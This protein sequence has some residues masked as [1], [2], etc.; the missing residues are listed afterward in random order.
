MDD[1]AGGRK[2]LEEKTLHEL[3]MCQQS[4]LDH[5]VSLCSDSNLKYYLYY[6]TLLG[7][8]RHKG[9]IP[10]DDDMDVV[11]PRTDWEKLKSLLLADTEG[12]GGFRI[13]CH[14]NDGNYPEYFMRLTKRGTVFRTRY[15][16]AY[17]FNNKEVWI[18]IYPLDRTPSCSGPTEVF[19]GNCI[20]LLRRLTLN[21]MMRTT[22]GFGIK[23][24]LVHFL[25]IPVPEK[26]LRALAESIMKRW[27]KSD[28]EYVVNWTSIYGYEKEKMK[29]NYFEP[30]AYAQYGGK[31]Y[32]IP[33]KWDIILRNI[34]G[35][36]M[37]FPPADARN[38]HHALEIQL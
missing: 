16:D 9:P 7:A 3:H 24:K 25:L 14:E 33:G 4:I 21:K 11:M 22:S 6:G 13:H 35:N 2:A 20:K 27:N 5:L 17:A 36:Y 30:S 15:T 19:L 1:I 37:E 38:G 8:I 28:G 26:R 31:E 12:P 34:Y 23:G 18:D 32:V 29:L 10:W